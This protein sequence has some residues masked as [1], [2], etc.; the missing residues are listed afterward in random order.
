MYFCRVHTDVV[1]ISAGFTLDRESNTL[2][3]LCDGSSIVLAFDAREALIQWQVKIAA[4]VPYGE[5]SFIH[6]LYPFIH[7]FYSLVN[8]IDR[9]RKLAIRRYSRGQK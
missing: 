7:L 8:V 6:L 5:C 3:L 2:A 1:C 9:G 4:S